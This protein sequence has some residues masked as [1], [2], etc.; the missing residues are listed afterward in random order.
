MIFIGIVEFRYYVVIIILVNLGK[1]EAIRDLRSLDWSAFS[2]FLS[3]KQVCGFQTW[4]FIARFLRFA[5][6]IVRISGQG[7]LGVYSQSDLL[8]RMLR[9]YSYQPCPQD[10]CTNIQYKPTRWDVANIGTNWGDII[11]DT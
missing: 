7:C 11:Y 5:I 8:D 10:Y 9:L 4:I 3:L 1:P 6:C 2:E